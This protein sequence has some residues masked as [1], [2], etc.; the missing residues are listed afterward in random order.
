M[1]LWGS[2]LALVD[3]SSGLGPKRLNMGRGDAGDAGRVEVD[4]TAYHQRN[5]ENGYRVEMSYLN[6]LYRSSHW[7]GAPVFS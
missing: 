4:R 2:V 7:A 3:V 1:A 6:R 5:V